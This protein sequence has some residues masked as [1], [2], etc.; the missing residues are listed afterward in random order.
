MQGKTE[1]AAKRLLED[2]KAL[3]EA[4]AFAVV[5]ECVPAKL[6]EL[7]SRSLS[8]P[9]IGIGAGNGCDGQVLVY[10]DMLGIYEQM[11]PKFVKKFGEVGAEMKA[12]F[13]R[14]IE[15]VKQGTFPAPEHTFS[16]EDEV[17]EKLYGSGKEET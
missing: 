10:H 6:A 16:I 15:Q 2:A 3:E 4:G 8:I 9:T 12:A 7:V 14:Y 17:L 11:T 1:Q 5:L 13:S